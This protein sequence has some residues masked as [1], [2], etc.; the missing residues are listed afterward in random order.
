MTAPDESPLILPAPAAG[1]DG[2]LVEHHLVR[3]IQDGS[4]PVRRLAEILGVSKATLYKIANGGGASMALLVRFGAMVGTLDFETCLDALTVLGLDG[5][6][7]DGLKL[8]GRVRVGPAPGTGYAVDLRT[9][10][11]QLLIYEPPELPEVCS[12]CCESA[13]LARLAQPGFTCQACLCR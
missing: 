7:R 11:T 5:A 4:V 10:S 13:I 12:V 1:P 3:C 8:R 6:L 2:K 9:S